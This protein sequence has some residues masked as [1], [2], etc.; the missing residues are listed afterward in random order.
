MYPYIFSFQPSRNVINIV[1]IIMVI[2]VFAHLSPW[3]G[4]VN[5]STVMLGCD[6]WNVSPTLVNTIITIAI[7]SIIVI[8][9]IIILVVVNCVII[10]IDLVLS[11]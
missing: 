3:L 10:I 6:A 11:S 5:P 2:I 8:I 4:S 9:I 1:I 7:I